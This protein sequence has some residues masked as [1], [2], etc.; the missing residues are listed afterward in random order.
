MVECCER[1]K[2]YT[3]TKR[4][5]PLGIRRKL[6]RTGS[7]YGK[8]T[9]PT[10]PAGL[11]AMTLK[12]PCK[13]HAKDRNNQTEMQKQIAARNQIV[14]TKDKWQNVIDDHQQDAEQWQQPF[15]VREIIGCV[16]Q[17]PRKPFH[18]S[19]SSLGSR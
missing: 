18:N 11:L 14:E 3:Q 2:Q 9:P 1:S 6:C 4:S 17:Q 16:I 12:C 8:R 7:R 19:S 15:A 5:N 13:H 10:R